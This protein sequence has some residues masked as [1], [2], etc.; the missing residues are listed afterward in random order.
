MKHGL[1]YSSRRLIDHV[2]DGLS[3]RDTDRVTNGSTIGFDR[4]W[5]APVA[6]MRTPPSA[7]ISIA[8]FIDFVIDIAVD[9]WAPESY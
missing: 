2:V 5:L 7:T 8:I 4:V 9:E 1:P 3:H 6:M